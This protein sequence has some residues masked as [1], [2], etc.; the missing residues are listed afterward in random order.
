MTTGAIT[1][2]RKQQIVVEAAKGTGIPATNRFLG[3]GTLLDM[4][5][6]EQPEN[7][8]GVLDVNQEAPTEVEQGSQLDLG[9]T[10]LSYEQLPYLLGAGVLGGVVAVEETPAQ[11]DYKYTYTPPAAADPNPDTLTIEGVHS[12]GVAD[13]QALEANY[14]FVTELSISASQ[15]REHAQVSA[16]FIGRKALAVTPTADIAVPSRTLVPANLWGVKFA[17]NHAGLDGASVIAGGAVSFDWNLVTGLAPK[18]R[19]S[20]SLE[21]V[22]HQFGVGRLAT[23]ALTIDLSAL[24]ETERLSFFRAQ[25]ERA[26]RLQ[27]DGPAIG[28]GKHNITIDGSYY[29]VEPPAEPG[30][31][32]G[33][34]TVTLNYVGFY[35]VAA[36]KQFEVLVTNSQVAV[37]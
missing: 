9:P 2:L 36:A 31:D 5:A 10:E 7:D 22:E 8:Y 15:G 1:K 11:A 16:T 37:L 34:E 17:A 13:V 33:Q 6:Q 19:L 25:T 30:D 4:A 3:P 14:C 21:F 28:T 29:L 27:V 23:L 18:F 20:E 26:I 32:D 12:D 35:E 24:L